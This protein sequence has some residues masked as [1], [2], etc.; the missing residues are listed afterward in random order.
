MSMPGNDEGMDLGSET[1]NSSNT[2][3]LFLGGPMK[4]KCRYNHDP[5]FCSIFVKTCF[6]KKRKKKKRN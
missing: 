3:F 2:P 1:E 4:G 5:I 6:S